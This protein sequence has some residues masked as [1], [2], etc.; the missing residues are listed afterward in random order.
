LNTAKHC[1]KCNIGYDFSKKFCGKCGTLLSTKI[2]NLSD[3]ALEQIVT[4]D[5]RM[6][7]AEEVMTAVQ[8]LRRRG[9]EID[10]DVQEDIDK[11]IYIVGL[12]DEELIDILSNHWSHPASLVEGAEKEIER[13][14]IR[15]DEG[16]L[17]EVIDNGLETEASE[18]NQQI[19]NLEYQIEKLK[20]EL[21]RLKKRENK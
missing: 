6:Y 2:E 3:K 14:G 7:S 17:Q 1:F 21:D 18:Q 11:Y 15:V 16:N 5:F 13:R 10:G 4:E 8:E 9:Y 19:E 20:A 12:S